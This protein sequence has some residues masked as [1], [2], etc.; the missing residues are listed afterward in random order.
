MTLVSRYQAPRVLLA[1]DDPLETHLLRSLLRTLPEPR[2]ELTIA[3]IGTA[4]WS[5]ALPRCEVCFLPLPAEGQ[6]LAA[7]LGE[8]TAAAPRL[9][10][11]GMLGSQARYGDRAEIVQ[12]MRS[13]LS[14]I[15]LLE[16]LSLASL[17]ELLVPQRHAETDWRLSATTARHEPPPAAPLPATDTQ[18]ASTLVLGG[19]ATG[20]WRIELN[21]QKA[22]F[23]ATTLASLG[24]APGTIGS[25]LGDW[26][27]LIHADD[28]DRLVAEVHAVLNGSASPH[29]VAYRLQARDGGWLAVVSDDIAV[30]LDD[31]GSPRAIS[32]HFYATNAQQPG[33]PAHGEPR[34]A[35]LAAGD[36]AASAPAELL[37]TAVLR[38][39]RDAAGVFRV[40]WCNPAAG[41]LELREPRQLYGL[42]PAEFS[43]IFDGYDLDEA[44]ARVHQTGI[45]EAREVMARDRDEQPQWRSYRI[46]RLDDDELLLEASDITEHVH[47]RMLRRM[48]D[49]MAQYLVRALPLTALLLDEHGHVVQAISVAGEPLGNDAAALE[50]R[51]LDELFGDAAGNA[52]RQQIQ[53]TLNTGRIASGIYAIESTGGRQWLACRSAVVR[54]RPGMPQR[55]LLTVQNVSEPVLELAETRRAR[56]QWHDTIQRIPLPLF[57]KDLD[58][59]YLAINP[60]FG[61]LHG[62]E[63]SMLLGKTDLEVFPD[64][65]AMELHELSQRLGGAAEAT[66]ERHPAGQGEQRSDYC[67][68]G[69]PLGRPGQ[70]A[71]GSGCLLVPLDRLQA[72][73]DTGTEPE[74]PASPQGSSEARIDAATTS[75][76][77]RVEQVLVEAGDYADVLRQLEQLAETTM[78]AQ[79]MIHE[80]AGKAEP[81]A[82]A[83]LIVL[84]PLAQNIIDLERI[85]LPAAARLDSEIAAELPLAHCDPL[86]FNQVLLR[87]L[88]HARRGLAS[89]GTLVV[90]LRCVE[91]TRLTCVSCREGFSGRFVEVAIKDDGAM[92]Y[93]NEADPPGRE[94]PD[95]APA[96]SPLGDLA[97]IHDLVHGQG[98]HLQIQQGLPDGNSLHV[99]FRAAGRESDDNRDPRGYTTVTRFPFV[100][101]R[102]PR[103][104]S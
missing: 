60:A 6:S 62:V 10:I 73:T 85:L 63:E 93:T 57:L 69:F 81:S 83:P 9:R 56:D 35:P 99:Y 30:E 12:A 76:V 96:S 45:S 3:E 34:P 90:R 87:C 26:K 48:D 8:I 91:A 50:D 23:D 4:A 100:R 65:L 72:S 104:L 61:E 13:G 59:R 25:T 18:D 32:G 37:S 70:P 55:A 103:S 14:D 80:I 53:K 28:I 33:T 27:A 86:V 43:P 44:L 29:P 22:S 52:C 89:D 78:H 97:R 1:A 42:S 38:L 79:A 75:V 24:H 39:R 31:Q 16:E 17:R 64:E 95:D 11:V 77:E 54:G 88:R 51:P 92:P 68:F 15:V 5:S 47:Q 2:P 82:T 20:S 84:E 19:P 71:T 101:L 66:I 94:A 74:A 41:M 67:W 21:D 49:E 46:T 58:G 98:G 102:D 40:S 36:D 7:I